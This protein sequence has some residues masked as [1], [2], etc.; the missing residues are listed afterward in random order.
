MSSDSIPIVVRDEVRGEKTELR[1]LLCLFM[2]FHFNS[3]VCRHVT[4][5]H[6]R[7]GHVV[8]LH[9]M[10]FIQPHLLWLDLTVERRKLLRHTAQTQKEQSLFSHH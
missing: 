2:M 6:K 1:D 9:T 5:K 7:G 4:Y 10:K 3:E 8:S